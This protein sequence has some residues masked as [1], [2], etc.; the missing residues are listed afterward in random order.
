MDKFREMERFCDTYDDMPDGAF[1]ALAEDM[2]GWTVDDWVWYA[3]KQ[4][5]L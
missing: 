2:H 4:R 1:F 5:G 3:D